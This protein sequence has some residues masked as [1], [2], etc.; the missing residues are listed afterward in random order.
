[1]LF[2]SGT[3]ALFFAAFAGLYWLV[4]NSLL[5]RNLLILG[6]SWLFYGWWDWRFLGL[7]IASS[8]LDHHLGMAVEQASGIRRRRIV[9]L[10]VV[11]NLGLLGFFKYAGFFADSFARLLQT[12][13]IPA[14]RPTLDIVL[15]VGIS[16]YTFQSLG[17]VTDIATGRIKACRDRVQF[18]AF[19]AF[20]PQLVAG[21][22]E[23]AARL[24]PQFQTVRSVSLN[25][26]RVGL[27]WMV[28]GLFRKVAVA[29]PCGSLAEIAFQQ[30]HHTTASVLLGVAAFSFQIYGDFAGY[31]DMAR[32]LARML[33]FDLMENFALPYFATNLREFWRRWHI[34]L[35]EWLRDNIYIPLGGNRLGNNRTAV[36]L[37]ITLVLGGFWHG[38]SWHFVAWGAWH[39][40][41]LMGLHFLGIRGWSA[42][43][44]L[45]WVATQ[46]V[47]AIGWLLFRAPDMTTAWAMLRALPRW[48]SVAWAGTGLGY[49]LWFVV[50][51]LVLDGIQRHRESADWGSHLSPWPRALLLGALIYAIALAWSREPASFLYFQF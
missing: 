35:S 24:L 44:L 20:F 19:V 3:F 29:D 11:V 15:P 27:W 41:A 40:L 28:L 8:L 10:S 21:P 50:P 23:R 46:S 34:S 12:L 32:G 45:G 9:Q 36:N 18:L 30:P 22:I 48:E 7:L 4:R 33:G 26:L 5:Q 47:V 2:N 16:F 38:A 37:G 6:A 43:A 39:G 1:M 17:Y 31:S 42:P 51:M 13:G 25:D 49:L 14:D